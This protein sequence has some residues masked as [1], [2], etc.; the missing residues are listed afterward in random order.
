[1]RS[2]ILLMHQGH[3]VLTFFFQFSKVDFPA[4]G[5]RQFQIW[6]ATLLDKTQTNVKNSITPDKTSSIGFYPSLLL[7]YNITQMNETD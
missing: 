6:N 2:H 7:V 5:T 3:L 4:G 1:M